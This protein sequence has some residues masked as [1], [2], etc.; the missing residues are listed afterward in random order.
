MWVINEYINTYNT[1]TSTVNVCV[2]KRIG[3]IFGNEPLYV[4]ILNM[5][6]Y[7]F[8]SWMY[9]EWEGGYLYCFVSFEI[10]IFST[11]C[12]SP[13][14]SRVFL[15]FSSNLLFFLENISNFRCQISHNDDSL[16]KKKKKNYAVEG[17][18]VYRVGVVCRHWSTKVLKAYL[19]T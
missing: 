18:C 5:G 11:S 3:V 1:F 16:N 12:L 14:S 9:I 17:N 7:V 15:F 6:V 8:V 13:F 10:M 2:S 4:N 19:S